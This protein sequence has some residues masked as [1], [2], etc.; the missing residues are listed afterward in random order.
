[1]PRSLSPSL[2]GT[3]EALFENANFYYLK[4]A[5]DLFSGGS[6]KADTLS[7]RYDDPE[8]DAVKCSKCKVTDN[9][10]FF[11]QCDDCGVKYV[12]MGLMGLCSFLECTP[13][14]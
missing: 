9:T 5:T 10:D 6:A 4:D 13:F 11:V 14:R 8:H 2:Q 7:R 1:M 3:N 12:G